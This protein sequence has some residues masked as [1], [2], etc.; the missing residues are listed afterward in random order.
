MFELILAA[1]V[2]LIIG[3]FLSVCIYRIPESRKEEWALENADIFEDQEDSEA[4]DSD[5]AQIPDTEEEDLSDPSPF[6]GLNDPKRSLCPE[7]HEQLYWWHNLPL[8]SWIILRGK[9]H[10]CKTPISFRYP[11]VELL[12]GIAA[13]TCIYNFGVSFTGIG[14][15]LFLATLIVITFIDIDYYIIPNIITLPGIVVGLV[16][17]LANTWF[18]F[19]NNPFAQSYKDSLIGLAIGG[20]FFWLFSVG[21]ELLRG[22]VGL[23]MGDV[24]LLGMIG[25]LFGARA[26]IHT[27]FLGSVL[28][29]DLWFG[30][31][32]YISRQVVY[33][34]SLWTLS[35]NWRGGLY[36]LRRFAFSVSS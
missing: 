33:S 6:K 8:I 23:G 27:I 28:G 17:G 32:D 30:N 13:F 4:E 7:C 1:I 5:Q 15:F 14:L 22:R 31:V 3:S 36:I 9:C 26:A 16:L 20:G 25:A 11:L 34:F 24:K 2:G 18:H 29:F 21:Y 12:S 35:S 10:F 19:L